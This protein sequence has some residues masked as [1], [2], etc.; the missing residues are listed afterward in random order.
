M[1]GPPAHHPT[2]VDP[3]SGETWRLDVDFLGSTWTCIWGDGCV[4][5]GDE[6]DTR[7]HRGCCSLGAELLDDEVDFVDTVWRTLDPARFHRVA[8]ARSDGAV[9]R[10]G[11]GPARTRVVDDACVF[12]NPVDGAAPTGCALHHAALDD[13]ERPEDWKPAVCWQLPLKVDRS[14]GEPW[15]RAWRRADWGP[16][17]ATMAWCCTETAP[18]DGLPSA[19]VADRPVLESLAPELEALLGPSLWELVRRRLDGDR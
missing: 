1:P 15:L 17:G 11:D 13:G 5:I 19:F 14:D 3:D 4:G 6:A 18:G 7:S 10:D 9:V 8:T 12:F 2:V 16:G